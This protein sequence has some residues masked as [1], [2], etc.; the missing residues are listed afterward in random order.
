M[1][2]LIFLTSNLELIPLLKGALPEQAFIVVDT[3]EAMAE[4]IGEA[5]G[6]I[7]SNGLYTPENARII[8]ERGKRLQWIQ[9]T[10]SGVDI[11][12]ASGLPEGVVVAN[13]AGANAVAVAEHAMALLLAVARRIPDA[14]VARTAKKWP[15]REMMNRMVSLDGLTMALV[16][17]GAIGREIARKAKAFDMKV[18]AITRS[19][20]PVPN[21]DELRPRA[22]IRETVGITDVVCLATGYDASSHGMIDATTVAAMKP[23][24]IVVNIARGQMIDERA[25]IAALREGRLYGAGIDVAE[26]EP[27]DAA[28]ELWTLPNVIMTPHAAGGGGIKIGKLAD[29]VARNIRAWRAG[30]PLPTQVRDLSPAV[31]AE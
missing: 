15:R 11:A 7:V 20:G 5:A 6:L 24:A 27:P 1:P 4:R 30:K 3:G 29:I 21:V 18:I 19:T 25:L 16:G 12:I 26:V 13:A 10:T 22:R 2:I 28:S 14:V 8:R 31:P 17:V 9:F 23:G